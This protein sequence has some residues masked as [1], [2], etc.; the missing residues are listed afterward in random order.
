MQYPGITHHGAVERVTG[1]CHEL[2]MDAFHSLLVDCGSLLDST[3]KEKLQDESAIQFALD[4]IKTVILTHV[5]ADHIGRIPQL[6]AAGYSGPIL[7]SE[8]SAHL[9]PVVL[10]DAFNHQFGRSP[11]ERDKYLTLINKRIV[12]LPFGSWFTI[13]ETDHLV[14]KIRLQRAGHIL[15]SA[16]VECDM[17]YPLENRNKRVVFSGDLGSSHTPFLPSPKS[18]ERADVLVL[19]STYGDRLHEDRASQQSRLEQVID[20][21]LTDHG[22]VLI[23][24]FSIGRTQEL[25][26]EIEDILRRKVLDAVPFPALPEG[27]QERPGEGWSQ[28]PVILDSPLAARFTR[29]Y[30]EF[31]D[32]WNADAQERQSE[33]RKPLA[34]EQLLTIDS[35]DKHLQVVN[36]LASTRR[37]AIVIAGHGMC[38][39]GR[40]VNY[41]KAMLGDSRHNVVFV[42][43]QVKG[44]PGAAIQKYGPLGGYVELDRERYG[45]KAGVTTIGG[46]SA[47]ADQGEL[48]EFV[49]GMSV[50]PDEIKLVHGENNAKQA[51]SALLKRKYA[52]TKRSVSVTI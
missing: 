36:Y 7:C 43:Y 46:Y 39:G 49:A 42:G 35:H 29:I 31:N 18:P 26:Y 30:R 11:A 3:D 45:I 6:L 20:Q 33:G 34:F 15:G 17:N 40:I 32:Y 27:M 41:L 12:A 23:P 16:Y 22:T 9:L 52:I 10:E 48:I 47:H 2:H 14:C 4:N 1:S 50:W 51:L 44:T 37:P 5:H 13:V 8:P 25:L 38:A 24:A 28:L 19:E 21:A